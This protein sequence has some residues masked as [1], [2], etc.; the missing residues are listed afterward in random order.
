MKKKSRQ[1]VIKHY[2]VVFSLYDLYFDDQ[3]LANRELTL[4]TVNED[5]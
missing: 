3:L 4:F 2:M 5:L 1:P